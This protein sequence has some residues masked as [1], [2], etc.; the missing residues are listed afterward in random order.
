MEMQRSNHK[1]CF[2]LQDGN[3][4]DWSITINQWRKLYHRYLCEEKS[5]QSYLDLAGKNEWWLGI[6]HTP[7]CSAKSIFLL[8]IWGGWQQTI[9]DRQGLSFVSPPMKKTLKFSFGHQQ[10]P[11]VGP[12]WQ[13]L[14]A[15]AQQ[16][17]RGLHLDVW[18]L[19]NS[20]A[21]HMT[22]PQLIKQAIGTNC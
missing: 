15:A 1:R 17:G 6:Y 10:S 19:G 4:R 14:I 18:Q 22:A 9:L 12:R 20:D 13:L 7:G 11:D 3:R 5:K 21:S 2:H 16:E 8:S